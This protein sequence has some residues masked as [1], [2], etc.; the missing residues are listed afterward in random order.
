[1]GW[2]GHQSG[3]II[4]VTGDITLTA[5]FRSTALTVTVNVNDPSYGSVDMSSLSVPYGSVTSIA[6][7]VLTIGGQSV[8]ATPAQ[9]TVQYTYIF[10]SWQNVPQTVT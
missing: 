3:E 7:N 8:T 10:D 1:M 9:P 4:T 5:V 2:D 6:G